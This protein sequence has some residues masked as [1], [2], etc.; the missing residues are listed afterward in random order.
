MNT[1]D[2]TKKSKEELLDIIQQLSDNLSQ[3]NAQLL[4]VATL[5]SDQESTISKLGC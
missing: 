4:Y 5:N 2:Y 3:K 1:V